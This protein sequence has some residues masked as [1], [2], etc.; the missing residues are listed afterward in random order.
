MSTAG[1]M[2]SW[3]QLSGQESCSLLGVSAGPGFRPEQDLFV[4]CWFYISYLPEGGP[5]PPILHSSWGVPTWLELGAC[6]CWGR[7]WWLRRTPQIP[8][9]SGR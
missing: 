9:A 3:F 5:L 8:A 7:G 4:V 1:E 6:V 2:G